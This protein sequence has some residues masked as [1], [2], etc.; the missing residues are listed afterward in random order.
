LNQKVAKV[1]GKSKGPSILLQVLAG[2]TI[3]ISAKAFYNIDKTLPGKGVDIAPVVGS[4]IVAMSSPV[5]GI[6][7]TQ[8]AVDLGA[9]ASQSIALVNV[10]QI[11]DK[12]EEVKPQSGI[13]FVLYNSRM[14]VVKENTG[15]LLV[16]DKINEIQTLATDNLI[17]QEA[18][19]LEVYINN[20]A[21]TPVYYDN[22]TVAATTSNVVEV[23]AYYPY[24]MIIPGLSL[25]AT[26]GKWNGYKYSAKELQK[27]LG[28][29]WLDLGFRM[30]DPVVGRFWNV[31]PIAEKFYH[32][33]PYN[34]AENNPVTGIDLWG[35]QYLNHNVAR[36]IAQ[37]GRV[38]LKLSNFHNVTANRIRALNNN[39]ANWKPG[40]IGVS[41]TV[42]HLNFSPAAKAEV[43]GMDNGY[44]PHVN[45]ASNPSNINTERGEKKDGTP[46]M[47][48]KER[49]IAAGVAS[50]KTMAKGVLIVDA[51]N[52]G[53][54][55]AGGLLVAHDNKL[56]NEHRSGNVLGTAIKDVNKAITQGLIP[57]EY[58]N[59]NSLTDILNVVL[60][61]ES[62]TNSQAIMD[63][64]EK[65]LQDISNR[66]NEE[67]MKK[68]KK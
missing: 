42:G 6:V 59:V 25:M 67:W 1:P 50:S 43:A 23:N 52:E 31:D 66:Y 29:G 18:G 30:Y 39:S 48:Q 17:M 26:P 49:T 19:F 27:E 24:G 56:L 22:F 13:N 62:T 32:V 36:I 2:D 58:M 68:I 54:Q 10:P 11:V 35:L 63:I 38:D 47:R 64:G 8:L 12:N 65:I 33:T 53:L 3:S 46:D 37:N 61:G 51:I 20:E 16:E 5:S 60:Q 34:Y 9:E 57:N 15:V 40:H 7:G 41:Q 45:P 55:L 14:E 21:Q 28:L 4:A 44:T